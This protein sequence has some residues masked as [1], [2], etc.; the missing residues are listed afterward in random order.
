MN[1]SPSTGTPHKILVIGGGAGGLEL[2]TQ[3]GH[4][5]RKDPNVTVTLV[6]QKRSHI[7]KPLLHEV[8]TGSLDPST[9]A[10]IYHAHA[11]KHHYEFQLGQFCGLSADKKQITLAETLDESGQQVLPERHLDYDTL[12]MAIGSVSNDFN[13]PGVS[14]HC[15]FLDTA[16]QAERFHNALINNFMRINQRD[17]GVLNIAIVGAGATGVEL[18]AEL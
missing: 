7:W 17:S 1:N 11:V 16:K 10:V 13:T 9:D 6:D 3:L 12:V 5:Y 8:A 14:D 18:S 2:V 15:F 4:R